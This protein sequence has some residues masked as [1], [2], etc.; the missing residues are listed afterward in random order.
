[1]S[2]NENPR[3]K[4]VEALHGWA[5][6]RKHYAPNPEHTTPAFKAYLAGWADAM[7]EVERLAARS[8]IVRKDQEYTDSPR[9]VLLQ[10]SRE[11]DDAG[12][13]TRP[14]CMPRW[15]VH[16]DRGEDAGEQAQPDSDSG[17]SEDPQGGGRGDRRVL[18]GGRD[19]STTAMSP[20]L[21]ADDS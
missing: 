13:A 16:R 9:L 2:D 14:D 19:D 15:E 6:Y 3:H 21:D 4:R 7:K 8:E 1:M 12:G 5:G 20:Q 18:G 17:A 11:R 10:G